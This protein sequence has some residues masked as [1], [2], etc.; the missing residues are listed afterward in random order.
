MDHPK[1]PTRRKRS[2][3]T[4]VR[5]HPEEDAALKQLAQTLNQTPSRVIRSLIRQAVTGG[6]DY[7]DAGVLEIRTAH[8]QLAAIGRNLNQL[9]RALNRGDIVGGDDLRRVVNAGLVQMEAVK[10]VYFKAVR[11]T[12]QRIVL[13]LYKE[14]GLVLPPQ[15]ADD[16]AAHGGL[17]RQPDRGPGRAESDPAAEQGG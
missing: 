9:V 8:R 6:P 17:A 10:G 15:A 1:P 16:Q 4:R 14:A 2:E 13:P 3:N 5:L 12:M 7:F 11:A